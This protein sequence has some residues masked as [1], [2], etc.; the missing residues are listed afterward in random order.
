[1]GRVRDLQDH[2]SDQRTN[3]APP[4][5]TSPQGRACGRVDHH[6]TTGVHD[7]RQPEASSWRS[8]HRDRTP[9]KLSA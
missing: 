7:I 8:D 9:S 4:A 3:R 5:L 1:M 2:R 6:S